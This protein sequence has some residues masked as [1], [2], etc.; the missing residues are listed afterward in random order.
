MA[1]RDPAKTRQRLVQPRS[2]RRS[3]PRV[4]CGVL[5]TDGTRILLGHATRSPRWDIPKGVADTGESFSDAALR[6]LHEE[7]GL[8]PAAG[9]LIGLG[10]HPYLRGKDIFLLAWTPDVL[11]D[12]A[13]LRCTS[14][15]ETADGRTLPEFDRFALFPL[16]EAL[17]RIGSNLARV[18]SSLDAVA[19]LRAQRTEARRQ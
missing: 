6:E 10:R 5:V 9:D 1:K 15:F 2:D 4:T 11:P 13:T 16:G 8:V 7:T 3:A 17:R 14:T 12:P 18:L 19:S